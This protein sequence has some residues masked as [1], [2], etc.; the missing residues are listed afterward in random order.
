MAYTGAYVFGDS[1]VDA[2]NAL[3]L[4]QW[5]GGLPFTDLPEGAPTA[6][7]GYFQGR[8]SNGYTFADLVS[9]KAIGFVSKPVF[10]FGYED[11][12]FGVPIDPFA[13]DPSGNNLNFAYGGAH[14]IRGDEAVPELDAQTDAF[15]DAVDGDA[16]PNALYLVTFGGNDVRDLAPTGSDPVPQILAYAQLQEVADDLRWE[17]GQLIRDGARN[18]VITGMAD[19]GSI[20]RYDRD[21]NGVLDPTEQ[22]RSDAATDYSI[23]LDMLIRTQVVP[24]LQQQLADRGLDPNGIVYVPIMDFVNASGETVTGAFDAS[25]PTIAAL[26]GLSLDELANNL[27][28]HKE[29]VFFDHVHPNAQAHALLASYMDS[30]ISGTAWV[31]TMPLFGADVDYRTTATIGAV[32]EVDRTSIA[33]VTGTTY[34]FQM[35][36]VSTVTPFVLDQLDIASLGGVVLADPSL[37]LLSSAGAVVQSD[38]D[39]GIGLDSSLSFSAAVAGTYTLEASAIGSLTGSYVLTATVTGAAMQAGNTYTVNSAL[40]L[41]LER[42]GGVGEDVVKASV[43]YALAAGSEIE[44][45]RTTNDHGKGAI[46]LSG[47]EF[48]QTIFG[49]NGANVLEGKGGADVMTGRGGS[50]R[51]VLS[52]APLTDPNSIDTITDYGRGDVVDI[53]QILS[54]AASTDVISG[55]YVRVTTSGLIQVDL[56]GGGDSWVTLSTINGN[57]AVTVRYLSGGVTA[58]VSVAR[59][60]DPFATIATSTGA[61]L[62]GALAAAGLAA[63]PPAAESHA[64]LEETHSAPAGVVTIVAGLAAN[65]VEQ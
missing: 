63:A 18:I 20:P 39:S 43:S 5:Y 12:V 62:T 50:D 8:F 41:V 13:G 29:L 27:L 26:N 35:L 49:N 14:V 31:E 6:S 28:A 3:K 22:L 60:N 19:V 24:A 32:G 46:N 15:R 55:G 42:A 23:H 58:N 59:V 64:T 25:L 34:T 4:A 2:G 7:L 10:P 57:G 33:M 16:P 44:V 9:N 36:G 65:A 52:S 61:V 17:V 11:P 40:T 53:A 1:L 21:G 30:L 54:V 51:F 37:R 45:L 47:N 38:D 48:D 56:N